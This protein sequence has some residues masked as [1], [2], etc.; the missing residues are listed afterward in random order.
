M[1]NTI[2]LGNPFSVVIDLKRRL[3]SSICPKQEIERIKQQRITG[4]QLFFT[5]KIKKKAQLINN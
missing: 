1:S 2:L 5:L 4:K 3:F